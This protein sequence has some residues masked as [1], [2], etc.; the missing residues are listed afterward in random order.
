MVVLPRDAGVGEDVADD[1]LGRVMLGLR[2]P[3]REDQV[4]ADRDLT[5]GEDVGEDIDVRLL[6]QSAEPPEITVPIGVR[7]RLQLT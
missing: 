5:R 6:Q 4:R 3:G 7:R 2:G 1:K